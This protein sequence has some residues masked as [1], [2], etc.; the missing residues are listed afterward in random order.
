MS[1][2][3]TVREIDDLRNACRNKFIWGFY[4]GAIVAGISRSYKESE[5]IRSSEELVRTHMLA[6]HT[7]TDL[8]ASEPTRR[9]WSDQ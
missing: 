7:A 1:R 3:Y 6:G 5:M 2:A 9:V 4:S 8:L